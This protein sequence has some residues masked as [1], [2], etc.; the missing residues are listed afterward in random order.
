MAVNLINLDLPSHAR[1]CTIKPSIAYCERRSQSSEGSITPP[2]TVYS[3]SY[4]PAATSL[5][6]S[7]SYSLSPRNCALLA[8]V[9]PSRQGG[10]CLRSNRD[11]YP[12]K[13]VCLL[14]QELPTVPIGGRRMCKF[15]THLLVR[16]PG[17][18][19]NAFGRRTWP[20]TV[21]L[22]APGRAVYP[23]G[24]L[25]V[26]SCKTACNRPFICLLFKLGRRSGR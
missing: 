14:T 13:L 23:F 5:S 26:T 19:A 20:G 22:V 10:S 24:L 3:P 6:L 7:L 12:C 1:N 16:V 11:I 4:P 9:C 15:H 18:G 8:P 25:R 21:S 2:M 17:E